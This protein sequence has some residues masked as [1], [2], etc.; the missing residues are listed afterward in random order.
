MKTFVYRGYVHPTQR[1]I[2]IWHRGLSSWCFDFIIN[3]R[4]SKSRSR[5]SYQGA[6]EAAITDLRN[7]DDPNY[8]IQLSQKGWVEISVKAKGLTEWNE[9]VML[10]WNTHQNSKS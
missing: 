7:H 2:M 6:R 10:F 5:L 9:V 3:G 1:A 4:V 8:R